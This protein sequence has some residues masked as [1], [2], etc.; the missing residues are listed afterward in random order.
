[1]EEE[2]RFFYNEEICTV[3]DVDNFRK[4]L[5]ENKACAE[6][7]RVSTEKD[8]RFCQALRELLQKGYIRA[9]TGYRHLSKV[10][11]AGECL[12]YINDGK[13]LLQLLKSIRK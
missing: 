8:I 11:A 12:D 7:L 4:F 6:A 2:L 1:M 10:E 3:K 13:R 9:S 5:E